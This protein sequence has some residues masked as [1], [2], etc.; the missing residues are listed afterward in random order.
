MD[1]I[2]RDR[3]CILACSSLGPMKIV[4]FIDGVMDA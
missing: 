3:S 2:L 1:V 4:Q